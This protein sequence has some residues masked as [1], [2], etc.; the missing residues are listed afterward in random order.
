MYYC[1]V[2]SDCPQA[3][4]EPAGDCATSHDS[5][6]DVLVHRKSNAVFVFILCCTKET[7]CPS[8]VA[9]SPV[10][11]SFHRVQECFICTC[12]FY[13]L[14]P[15]VSLTALIVLVFQ[16]PMVMLSLPRIFDD[17]P[18]AHLTPSSWCTAEGAVLV[19]PDGVRYGVVS[20]FYLMMT[21]VQ[22]TT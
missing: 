7:L 5:V 11:F 1:D 18:V 12:P 9:V 14:A 6:H 15:G 13:V 17:A 22:G 3:D 16:A 2:E 8:S 10:F 4:G 20:G 19:N 21:Q